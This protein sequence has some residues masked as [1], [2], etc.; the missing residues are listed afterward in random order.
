MVL[1]KEDLGR[2]CWARFK[3]VFG[4]F[5]QAW[6]LKAWRLK[7]GRLKA[8]GQWFGKRLRETDS[9][10]DLPAP[11]FDQA[12]SGRLS[13]GCDG[14]KTNVTRRRSQA[15][16]AVGAVDCGALAEDGRIIESC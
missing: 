12:R 3:Q 4:P 2:T 13:A 9:L 14:G 15:L 11:L 6:R 1:A 8:G 7:A 10:D 16:A 5:R